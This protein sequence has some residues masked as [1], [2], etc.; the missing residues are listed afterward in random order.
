MTIANDP[1][2]SMKQKLKPSIFNHVCGAIVFW[3]LALYVFLTGDPTHLLL[4][5]RG[6][7]FQPE[8]ATGHLVITGFVII[9]IGLW[10]RYT[11]Q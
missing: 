7:R 1:S 9:S 2:P 11:K 5:Q 8:E 3:L 6:G 10:K 4:S